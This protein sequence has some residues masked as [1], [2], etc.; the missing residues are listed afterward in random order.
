MDTYG[1]TCLQRAQKEARWGSGPISTRPRAT[2]SNRDRR[3]WMGHWMCPTAARTRREMASNCL[4]WT[5]A[6]RSRAQLPSAWEGATGDQIRVTDLE[7]VHSE[8]HDYRGS[9]RSWESEVLDHHQ[10]AFET[11]S[12]LDWRVLWVS[13]RYQIS[14]RIRSNRTR[15]DLKATWFRWQRPS[16]CRLDIYERHRGW[17]RSESP[18]YRL[19]LGTSHDCL[20]SGRNRTWR[21][22]AA[23]ADCWARRHQG[24]RSWGWHFISENA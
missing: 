13:A 17:L 14:Q 16:E 3:V 10:N 8:R 5:Q 9:D 12:S 11:P 22:R 15:R 2:L 1:P 24:V 21:P 23:Q 4:R 7:R 18:W 20:S 19:R 6:Q